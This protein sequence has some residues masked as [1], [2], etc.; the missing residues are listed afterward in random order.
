MVLALGV[1]S[2]AAG[3]WG[4]P[5]PLRV[6]GVPEGGIALAVGKGGHEASF[7]VKNTGGQP[8]PVRVRL[9]TS[10]EDIRL[11]PGLTAAF[12]SKATDATLAPGESRRV[13]VLWMPSR[14]KARE[15]YGHLAIEAGGASQ[16]FG[17]HGELGV[18]AGGLLSRRILSLLVFLPLLGALLALGGGLRGGIPALQRG[19]RW[20][21]TAHLAL[22]SWLLLTLERDLGR[23]DG[24]E[25]LQYIERGGLGPLPWSLGA[26][27]ASAAVVWVLSAT[28]V[29]AS[30]LGSGAPVAL[31][32]T[33]VAGLSL[34][35]LGQDLSLIWLGFALGAGSLTAL[36]VREGRFKPFGV[37]AG[38]SLGLLGVCFWALSGAAGGSVGA[39]GAVA[40]RSFALAALLRADLLAPGRTLLGLPMA[41]GALVLLCAGLLPLAGAWPGGG[42]LRGARNAPS[43]SLLAGGM[44]AVAVSALLRLG[45]L[46]VPE[47]VVW[48]ATTLSWGGAALALV[49][50]LGSWGEREASARFP[51]WMAAQ[52]GLALVGL[53]AGTAQGLVGAQIGVLAA[54]A[55]WLLAASGGAREGS[56]GTRLGGL[57]AAGV[58]GLVGFWGPAVGLLGA[59]PRFPGAALVAAAGW[60]LAVG[61]AVRALRGAAETPE[62]AAKP[63]H[64]AP[65]APAKPAHEEKSDPEAGESSVTSASPPRGISAAQAEVEPWRLALGGVLVVLGL[66]VGVVTGGMERWALDLASF[67][68]APGPAW[69]ASRSLWP[70]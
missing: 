15:V 34:A 13:Q 24:N 22:S 3:A 36:L 58:P 38:V 18:G 64:K 1:V 21:A 46:V 19:S 37:L 9:E 27:G 49:S 31:L 26:E 62:P 60:A 5:S 56:W 28:L 25:G 8:L 6:E 54:A 33:G 52:V 45:A 14:G 35:S 50:G 30:L 11:P 43:A 68:H 23:I 67:L 55:G 12:E 65:E 44:A 40:G 17:L 39:D 61:A 57:V 51:W 2:G 59:L 16:R 48:A 53:G 7:T 41:A 66:A 69:V 42:W 20:A 70:G 4:Q 63:A 10:D 29:M 47:G 32:A